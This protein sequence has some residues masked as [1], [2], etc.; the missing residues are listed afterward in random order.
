MDLQTIAT[1]LATQFGTLSATFD[2]ATET[3]VATASLPDSIDVALL[4]YPPS[5]FSLDMDI[6]QQ[7]NDTYDFAVR[8]LR[9]PITMPRRTAALY[10]WFQVLRDKA[11]ANMDLGLS[12]VQWVRATEGRM[13]FDGESYSLANGLY[14]P[15]DVV[16]IIHRV[17]VR[18]YVSTA[19]V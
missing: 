15:C 14:K 1:A 3:C 16:E 6:G 10:A 19:N 18:E 11:E 12:Y 4:V 13:E 7:R 5:A 2:G 17:R 9:D 8:L